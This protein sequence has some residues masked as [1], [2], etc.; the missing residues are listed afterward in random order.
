MGRL[1]KQHGRKPDHKHQISDVPDALNAVVV[2]DDPNIPFIEQLKYVTD[3]T[4]QH[5]VTTLQKPNG[6]IYGGLALTTGNGLEL[7][8]TPVWYILNKV[9]YFIGMTLLTLDAADPTLD[10]IDRIVVNSHGQY[11]VLKG[12]ASNMPVPRGLS[13]NQLHIVDILVKAGSISFTINREVVYDENTEWAASAEQATA[14]FAG[15]TF[16][17]SG[18]V[19]ADISQIKTGSKLIFTRET[20]LA[21]NLFNKLSLNIRLKEP[22]QPGDILF[23]KAYKENTQVTGDMPIV[24][25]GAITDLYQLTSVVLSWISAAEEFDCIVLEMFRSDTNE[26]AGFYL[27]DVVLEGGLPLT[28]TNVYEG[29]YLDTDI[30][31]GNV[32]RQ[33]VTSGDNVFIMPGNNITI[34]RFGHILYG[35]VLKIN[36]QNAA[37]TSFKDGYTFQYSDVAT[38]SIIRYVLD[39]S[40]N[41]KNTIYSLIIATNDGTLENVTILIN[42]VPVQGLSGITATTIPTEYFA[43]GSNSVGLDDIVTMT[44][45]LPEKSAV[46][47]EIIG[48]LKITREYE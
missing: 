35:N 19:C 24:I 44:G 34:E 43:T 18:S 47:T 28:A 9:N 38:R 41:Y 30:G 14:N 13:M 26:H 27:D 31:E 12:T 25:S 33:F 20:A 29:W 1:P 21:A 3:G 17:L 48:K 36:A 7:K 5:H 46:A 2:V 40:A 10:R 11:I 4:I 45:T 32:I 42:N 23:L 8:M 15:T 22:L 39:A 37:P 6:I 16:P